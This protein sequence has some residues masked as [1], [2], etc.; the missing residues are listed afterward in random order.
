MKDGVKLVNDL[1]HQLAISDV[2]LSMENSRA[3]E[4]INVRWKQLQVEE[5]AE[6]SF[7]EAFGSGQACGTGWKGSICKPKEYQWFG[8]ESYTGKQWWRLRGPRIKLST[9]KLWAVAE[10]EE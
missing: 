2:H 9:S 5:H 6:M 7:G 3:L 8:N 1:A 4:Q 10:L